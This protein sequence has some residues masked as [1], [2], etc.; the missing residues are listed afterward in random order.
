MGL[1]TFAKS[2]TVAELSTKKPT[3]PKPWTMFQV[4][5]GQYKAQGLS[6]VEAKSKAEEAAIEG[7]FGKIESLTD[8]RGLLLGLGMMVAT[9]PKNDKGYIDGLNAF[10]RPYK[11]MFSMALNAAL[12][13]SDDFSLLLTW[14]D[15]LHGSKP[16]LL[17]YVQD[18]RAMVNHDEAMI[19]KINATL[20]A[21]RDA[22]KAA[23][24]R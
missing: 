8:L 14:A 20:K 22:Y 24:A 18:T 19:D 10:R 12:P 4:L 9:A 3:T 23:R 6:E 5:E 1:S 7:Y 2:V 15:V 17:E 16:A 13:S 21:S 11:A